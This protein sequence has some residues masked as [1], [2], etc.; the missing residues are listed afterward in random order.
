MNARSLIVVIGTALLMTACAE[1]TSS[2]RSG[3]EPQPRGAADRE[4]VERAR[5]VLNARGESRRTDRDRGVILAEDVKDWDVA[6][7]VLTYDG[8]T[9]LEVSLDCANDSDSIEES[10]L[11]VMLD[12]GDLIEWSEDGDDMLVCTDEVHVLEKAAASS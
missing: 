3:P 7:S 1:S 12:P 10:Q 11:W 4:F 2:S 8:V 5:D 9:L 6:W